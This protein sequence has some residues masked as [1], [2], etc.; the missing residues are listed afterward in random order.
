MKSIE[1]FYFESPLLMALY[2]TGEKAP[3]TQNYYWIKYTDGTITPS[4]TTNEKVIPL[5]SGEVFPPI[6][7][8]DKGAIWSD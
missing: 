1:F 6:N 2:K 3:R 5:S 7:S 4:P 8:T